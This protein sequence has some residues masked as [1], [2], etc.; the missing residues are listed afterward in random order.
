MSGLV[1][2]FD[3]IRITCKMTVNGGASD[4]QN[5]F[6]TE[7]ILASELPDEDVHDAIASALDT[8]YGLMNSHF[9]GDLDYNTIETWNVSQDRPMIEDVWPVRT[10]GG[11]AGETEPPQTAP[12]V[13]FNTQ[14]A[15][16]QGRKFL[17]PLTEAHVGALG[18]LASGSK[19]DLASWAAAIL[20]G[21]AID[22]YNQGYFGNWNAALARFAPWYS[23][24]VNFY[25]ATQRRRHILV[26]S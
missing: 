23:A 20:G 16:S 18:E 21:W 9:P 11:G 7:C 15:R 13:L 25:V 4:V 1:S 10:S 3:I 5:V 22:A 19:T 8:A 12:L 14:V 2:P 26:G 6:H 17:P 24:I